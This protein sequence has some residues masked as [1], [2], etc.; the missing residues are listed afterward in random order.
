MSYFKF[1]R[2]L[3]VILY[4]IL[5][6]LKKDRPKISLLMPFSS[7]DPQRQ[8]NFDW[9]KQYWK[10]ELPNAEFI[11]G[12][13]NSEIFS[14]GEALNNAVSKS[15]GKVLVI[16]DADAYIEGSVLDYCSDMILENLDNHLWYIPYWKL[17]RL[18]Q[19]A[20]KL[21]TDSNPSDPFRFPTPIEAEYV[22]NTSVIVNYGRQYGA[23]LMMFP[24]EAYK[25][26]GNFDERFQGWGGEDVCLVRALDTL[27][28]KHKNTDNDIYHLWHPV[29]GN[30]YISRR[31]VGQTKGG[32]NWVISK[33]YGKAFKNPKMM[34]QL[35]K[36][37]KTYKKSK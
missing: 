33:R 15:N 28:G 6:F 37:S 19:P 21:V 3:K 25:L 26:I 24:R 8:A 1:F 18:N 12:T 5:P 23:M 4:N 35:I 20:A 13:C 22:E 2:R 27:Y 34:K 14:K 11:V 17:Y 16:I 7:T 29:Y 30:D 9:L 32:S 10:H 36:E 31:W